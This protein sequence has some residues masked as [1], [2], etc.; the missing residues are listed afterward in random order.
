MTHTDRYTVRIVFGTR[1][2]E[3][4]ETWI[5]NF[6]TRAEAEEMVEMLDDTVAYAELRDNSNNK[7]KVLK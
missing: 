3:D 1:M 4:V 7:I 5:E 6:K 2:F